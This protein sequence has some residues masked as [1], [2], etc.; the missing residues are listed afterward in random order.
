MEKYSR[1]YD[2]EGGYYD[3]NGNM[4]YYE[5]IFKRYGYKTPDEQLFKERVRE[6]FGVDVT[7]ATGNDMPMYIDGYDDPRPVVIDKRFVLLFKVPYEQEASLAGIASGR[8]DYFQARATVDVNRIVFYDDPQAVSDLITLSADYDGG[9]LVSLVLYYKYEKNNMLMNRAVRYLSDMSEDDPDI[10][11]ILFYRF[12]DK[13]EKQRFRREFVRKF[14]SY[15][16]DDK[17]RF[18]L[19]DFLLYKNSAGSTMRTIP[20]DLSEYPFTPDEKDYYKCLLLEECL[21]AYGNPYSAIG[22]V[23]SICCAD[24]EFSQRIAQK[25]YYELPLLIALSNRTGLVYPHDYP[26][27]SA[28]EFGNFPDELPDNTL[29]GIINDPDGYVN[30]REGKSISSKV[31]GKIV[32]KEEFLYWENKNSDWWKVMTHNLVEGYVHKSRIKQAM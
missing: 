21:A 7:R 8:E 12:A 1:M 27:P 30:I 10:R 32:D 29:H 5:A 26:E 14:L 11:H 17:Q 18:I 28:I 13:P 3:L 16:K 31:T 15:Y 22:D 19:G 25:H 24:P 4:P 6:Y 9:Y 2:N 20:N 23:R